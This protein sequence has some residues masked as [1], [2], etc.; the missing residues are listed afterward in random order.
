M[1]GMMN[2]KVALVTGGGTGIGRAAARL[3]AREG[4]IVVVANRTPD[5]GDETVRLVREAGGQASFV[6]TDVARADEVQRL[7]ETIVERHGR[8]DCA[9]NNGGIDGR[10]AEVVA[11]EEEDWD[12]IIDTNLKGTYLLMKHEIGQ[13]LRQGGGSIVNMS[14]VT[15]FI[16][17]PNRLAYNVSRHGVIGATKSAALEYARKGIRVNAVAPGSIRTAI[18]SRSTKGDPARERAYAEAHAVGR[19]GEPEEVAEAALW[20]LSDRASFVVGHTLLVDGGMTLS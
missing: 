10:P 18:F 3:F 20:L 15:G 8:L 1:N 17:R 14:S 5:T 9:F 16:V 12:S 11:C 7:I 6:R 13:M 2:G 4:A 19:V